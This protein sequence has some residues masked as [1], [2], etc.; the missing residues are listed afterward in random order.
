M[1]KYL[2]LILA[3][4]MMATVSMSAVAVTINEKSNDQSGSTSITYEVAPSYTVTIPTEVTLGKEIEVSAEKVVVEKGK[5]VKVK[6]D[7]Y[8]NFEL[9][10][11]EGAT[12]NYT[13]KN[14]NTEVNAGDTILTV[15]TDSGSVTLGFVAPATVTY[16]GTYTG[17]ITFTISVEQL[18]PR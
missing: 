9:K 18:A 8:S 14:G 13:V 17:T 1:K 12:I 7:S 2:A 10:T 11:A 15:A 5:A 16:A 3:I 6:I 4:M